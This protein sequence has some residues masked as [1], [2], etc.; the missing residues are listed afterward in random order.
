MDE[1][2][3]EQAGHDASLMIDELMEIFT[4]CMTGFMDGGRERVWINLF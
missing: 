2:E 1:E 4:A 3:A